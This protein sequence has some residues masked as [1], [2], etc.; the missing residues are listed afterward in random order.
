MADGD[1]NV[2][3]QE[4]KQEVNQEET[5]ES[6]IM[7]NLIQPGESKEKGSNNFLSSIRN[8]MYLFII[9][10][11]FVLL[12]VI[13][14]QFNNSLKGLWVSRDRQI[15][16][17][18]DSKVMTIDF[19]NQEFYEYTYKTSFNTLYINQEEHKFSIKKDLLTIDGDLN[20]FPVYTRSSEDVYAVVNTYS[21]MSEIDEIKKDLEILELQRELAQVK[22][23]SEEII[24]L[25]ER[26]DIYKTQLNK[27]EDD[28]LKLER[29]IQLK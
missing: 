10:A 7:N 29:V 16:Y 25:T 14:M 3:E 23:Q 1:N 26:I 13:L 20:S 27:L 21:I 11:F 4:V 5:N 12:C 6:R 2:N 17:F 22:G 9:L 18:T 24:R 8:K 15:L 28:L 19:Q